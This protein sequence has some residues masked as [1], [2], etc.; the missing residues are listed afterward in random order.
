MLPTSIF[1]ADQE[2]LSKKG[3]SMRTESIQ[4]GDVRGVE[5]PLD[6]LRSDG[7]VSAMRTLRGWTPRGAA[8]AL[9]V[10][11]FF[12]A[13]VAPLDARAE[14]DHAAAPAA[15]G[16]VT[17]GA[18]GEREALKRLKVQPSETVI[19][20]QEIHCSSCAKKIAAQLFKVKGVVRVRSDVKAN[21]T[22]VTPQAK[23][24][25]DPPVLW[26]AVQK[27]K[28]QPERLESPQGSYA[29]D[30]QTK[31][32]RKVAPRTASDAGTDSAETRDG[33]VK[34]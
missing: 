8:V 9:A 34:R 29:I 18:A 11:L 17:D 28:S 5:V 26:K 21:I 16:P 6:E 2:G 30:K 23:K 31:G 1:V 13:C 4:V 7:A 12:A 19:F 33:P 27:A 10:A 15:E 25:L 24:E 22:V 32:P 20:I 3:S 14:A